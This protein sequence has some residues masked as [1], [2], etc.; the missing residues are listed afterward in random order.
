MH[1]LNEALEIYRGGTIINLSMPDIS[2]SQL[3]FIVD[4]RR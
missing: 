1:F 3:L 2:L 4:E